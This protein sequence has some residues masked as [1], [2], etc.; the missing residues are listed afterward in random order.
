MA[1][2]QTQRKTDQGDATQTATDGG[3][4]EPVPAPADPG[5][6]HNKGYSADPGPDP[7]VPD[8]DPVPLAPDPD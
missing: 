7:A 5:G 6:A 1:E 4:D 8:E 3:L 2:Q